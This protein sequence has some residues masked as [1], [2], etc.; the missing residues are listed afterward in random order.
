MSWRMG[1]VR[2]LARW[3]ALAVV[4]VALYGC[5]DGGVGGTGIS[6]VVQ[7][8]VR[9]LIGTGALNGGGA[10]AGCPRCI[11]V[12]V[13]DHE[14]IND[15][16]DE[17]GNFELHGVFPQVAILDFF[18]LGRLKGSVTILVPAASVVNLNAVVDDSG[19]VAEEITVTF[20]RAL[21][22]SDP[23]C[24]EDP[25]E[26]TVV[27]ESENLF[28]VLFPSGVLSAAECNSKLCDGSR[29]TFDALQSPSQA[30]MEATDISEI[31]VGPGC[32]P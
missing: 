8:N 12:K 19:V 16:T 1:H 26:V 9:D 4:A 7:G 21:V 18:K 23:L 22:L 25:I 24:S 6:S 5:S 28:M 32:L 11:E 15:Q 2:G 17:A 10:A 31:N 20:D 13:R 14:E 30:R 3:A 27:D 29:I